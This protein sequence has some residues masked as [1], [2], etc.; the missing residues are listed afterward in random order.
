MPWHLARISFK[1]GCLFLIKNQKGLQKIQYS[2]NHNSIKPLVDQYKKSN[3]SL[4]FSEQE[5][6]LETE[7]FR[8]YFEGKPVD[9]SSLKLDFSAG[10]P[11]QRKIWD[12]T[13][14]IPFGCVETYKSIAQKINHKGYRSVGNALGKNPFLIAV[15]CHRVI[16]TD[17]SLGGFGAGLDLKKY[18]LHLEGTPIHT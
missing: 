4:T 8:R 9:F 15:P 14:K 11:F 12:I 7:L 10:T 5:F 3:I 13:Q 16:K 17:G 6:K 18:L 2:E 1:K